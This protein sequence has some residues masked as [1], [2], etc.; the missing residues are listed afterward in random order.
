MI[1]SSPRGNR[2]EFGT[3][4]PALRRDL[5]TLVRAGQRRS[6][7]LVVDEI[8]GR[9]GR[10]SEQVWQSLQR[11]DADASCWQAAT[12]AGWTRA[13]SGT[14]AR[15][16]HPLFVRI[17]LGSIDSLASRLA[18]WTGWLFA[19]A[20]V[21]GW[22]AVMMVA[23]LLAIA[24]STELS[25]SLGS[26]PQFFVQSDPRWLAVV[27]VVTK[28]A[29]E[30]GHAVCCCRIGS[31]CGSVGILLLCG[32]PCPYVDVTDVWR[33]NSAFKRAAVMLAG[34]Y[35]E[36]ILASL[37]TFTWVLA[38]DPAIRLHALNLMIVCGVSTILFNA[39][40]LMKYDGYFVLSDLIGSVNLRGEAQAAFRGFV[41]QPIAGQGYRSW[42]DA[43]GQQKNPRSIA[44]AIYHL[45]SIGYRFV[46]YLAIATFVLQVADFFQLRRLAV[47]GLLVIALMFVTR[48]GR[49][50]VGVVT[51]AGRWRG[52][53]PLRRWAVTAAM[54]AVVSVMLLI[55]LPRFRSGSGWI[56]IGDAESVFLSHDGLIEAVEFDFGDRVSAGDPLVKIKS[57]ALLFQQTELRGQV[58]LA[59]LRRD[60]SHRVTLNRTESSQ[61]WQTLQA[62]EHAVAERLAAVQRRIESATV[63][64]PIEGVVLPP[65]ATVSGDQSQS[66]WLRR[67]VGTAAETQQPWCRISLS[68][69]LQA[70]LI[71]DAR[72][73]INIDIGTPVKLCIPGAGQQTFVSNVQSVSAIE[74]DSK[75]VIRQAAY[76]VLCPLPATHYDPQQAVPWLGKECRAV[77]PLPWR[78]VAADLADWFR[79]WIDGQWS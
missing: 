78:S 46:V 13:R 22:I 15:S 12:A 6:Y 11:G 62:A 27:F 77:F 72:D 18:P 42:G 63:R 64:A 61:Q 43:T 5:A 38:N 17:P 70:V 60:L 21:L 52:V 66:L 23:F 79:G 7:R 55:P 8:S 73:R 49:Q 50:I 35:V 26:L 44:L 57:D 3:T 2:L 56:D 69:A 28:I 16:I 10:V 20:A 45:L 59:S 33:Q 1:D 37:A 30:L 36:L 54:L 31:R 39:N 4:R 29:H 76:Q 32:M 24:H 34:I 65:S 41:W 40:P 67:R 25:A 14:R 47:A 74:P 58:R 51:G 68:G 75:S 9:F 71:L 53:P 19:P 48:T